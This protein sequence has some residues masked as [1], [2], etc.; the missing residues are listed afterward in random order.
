MVN[1]FCRNMQKQFS[2]KRPASYFNK[3]CWNYWISICKKVNIIS[4]FI[5]DIWF[6]SKWIRELNIKPKIIKLLGENLCDLGTFSVIIPKVQPLKI[7]KL[8]F[9][10]IKNFSL[11]RNKMIGRNYLS[12]IYQ[13][14]DLYSEYIK[15]S[16][17]LRKQNKTQILKNK[18]KIW[19]TLTKDE[20]AKYI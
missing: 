10:K 4:I 20:D 11:K 2:S 13:T 16:Q 1:W 9:I 8:D 3:W 5:Y 17:R 7:N 6:N 14:K 19:K 15:N 12:T 18:Q